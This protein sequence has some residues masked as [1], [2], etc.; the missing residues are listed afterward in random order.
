MKKARI[1]ATIGPACEKRAI[2]EK[3]I[4]AGVNVCRLNFSFGTH[5]EHQK[6]IDMIRDVAAKAGKPIAI[7]QA[8]QG[9]K[10]RMGKLNNPV[11]VKKGDE[12]V[13]SGKS[14]HKNEFYLPTT[15]KN[16]AADTEPGKIILIADGKI[17]VEVIR[18]DRA[19]KEVYCKVTC[20]GTILTGKGIN[21][22]YTNISLPALTPKDLSDA[23][24]GAKAGV[25]YMSQ[26]FVRTAD[27]VIKLKKLLKREGH[28]DI[29][30]IAK[31]E[32][33]EA[34][35]NIDAILDVA[36]GV[37]V[38]R[39]DLADEISFAMVPIVQK[40]IIRKA[41][42]KGK[43]TII[44][45]EMLGSM[46]DSPLPSRAETSD[47]ANGIL[48]G[49]DAVMLSNETAMG[50][51]PLKAVQVMAE[52]VS[53]TEASFG[54][55]HFHRELDLPEKHELYE[56][57]CASASYLSYSLNERALAVFSTTGRTV[58]VLSEFRPQSI[59]YAL[60]FDERV[61]HRMAFYHNVLPILLKGTYEPGNW[62]KIF[63]Q[64]RKELLEKNLVKKGDKLI[65]L[66]GDRITDPSGDSELS[67]IHVRTVK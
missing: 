53:R 46:V 50:K 64:A 56:A 43:I 11:K 22:P 13:L 37:M 36:D 2:L 30:V 25:D 58:H 6:K 20:G 59:I 32:K 23:K 24:F 1:I 8:I 27:D 60:T 44:A 42:K 21:L 61:Y 26:S 9:P 12:I 33:P 51:Y 52:I 57:I 47:V 17:I 34:V 54:E 28:P 66:S 15:Y 63:L 62:Q 49:T 67:G 48:D 16:I 18:T 40:Q 55:E 31:I 35:E 39:G 65:V 19:K 14:Q 38:A 5:E 41:N 4:R 10:I 45:T 7:M 3:I 29:P